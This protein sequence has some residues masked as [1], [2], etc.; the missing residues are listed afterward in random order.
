MRH[1]GKPRN[2]AVAGIE[3]PLYR[4]EREAAALGHLQGVFPGPFGEFGIRHDAV[5]Q[6]DFERLC[7]GDPAVGVPDFL[8]PLLAHQ[9]LEIPG[10]V[11]GI[12][13]PHHRPDLAEHGALLGDR[14]VADHLQHVAAADREAVDAC[15]HRLLQ[16]V[17]RLVHFER[18]QHAGIE[19]GRFGAV[20]APADAEKPVACAGQH[21]HPGAGLAPDR[22]DALA[23]LVAGLDGKHVPVIGPVQRDGPDRAVLFI[24]DRLVAHS[25][26]SSF[27]GRACL[28][29][30]P[31]MSQPVP[32]GRDDALGQPPAGRDELGDHECRPCPVQLL[33]MNVVR[34]A[35]EYR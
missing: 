30:T 25:R 23:H 18:R 14:Q 10:A 2:A 7:G 31:A 26:A 22:V 6:P 1:A 9:I 11:A 29:E 19:P 17:D 24:E 8:G 34:R 28:R 33:G 4:R 12:E 27:V 16:L 20:L 32:A 15:D 13:R 21:D 5:D 35:G 3:R